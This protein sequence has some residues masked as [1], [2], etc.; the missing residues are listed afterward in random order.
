MQ[1]EE[2]KKVLDSMVILVDRREQPT[3]RAKRRYGSFGVP[4][5][6]AT[7]SYGD[8]SYNALLP[9]GRWILDEDQAVSPTVAIERKMN[10]DEL[11]SCFTRSRERFER[12][13]K[14]AKD[15]G[16]RIFLLVENASWE[17]LM[18]GK[19]A[20]RFNQR[21]FFASLC[22]WMVRYNIQL[23]FCKEETTGTIIK[24]LL[25]RD[26]KNRLEQDEIRDHA[27]TPKGD[28]DHAY[29]RRADTCDNMQ[30]E[31]YGLGGESSVQA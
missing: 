25:F 24:E 11:A 28:Q 31:E 1:E 16:A 22:S 14:R 4:Y 21:A 5:R 7:L 10:L 26:L 27:T 6:M 12:E 29:N 18:N 15:H 23:I 13:F 9:D 17:N 30:P 19:Y 20:S 8:Y 3:E 2:K